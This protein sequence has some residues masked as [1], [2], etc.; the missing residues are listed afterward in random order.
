MGRP[1]LIIIDGEKA[2]AGQLV[3][4]CCCSDGT[5]H[6]P[7]EMRQGPPYT[8]SGKGMLSFVER[9]NQK[10]QEITFTLMQDERHR[11]PLGA[12]HLVAMEGCWTLLFLAAVRLRSHRA[13]GPAF[14]TDR[15]LFDP[16]E[17]VLRRRGTSR[18]RA[19]L[20]PPAATGGM[21]DASASAAAT[22]GEGSSSL[23][24]ASGEAAAAEGGAGMGGDLH[25][26][27]L[28]EA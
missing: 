11:F 6:H 5:T 4:A 21:G 9:A 27:T 22:A 3:D 16:T 8:R 18:N 25:D 24:S 2:G 20:P 7:V 19:A 12:T 1:V 28:A 23:F 13:A 15:N 26:V 14:L 10:N 17:S